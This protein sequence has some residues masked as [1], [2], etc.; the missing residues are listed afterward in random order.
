MATESQ[1]AANQLNALRSTGP[2]SPEGKESSS[3]NA[4]KH[5]LT[6]R[7]A[8]VLPDEK[9]DEFL[10]LRQSLRAQ[11]APLD[12][13]RQILV[14][15]LAA[16]LW[17]LQRVPH[18]EAMLLQAS[19]T[20]HSDSDEPRSVD[21][22][23]QQLQALRDF[24]LPKDV[25]GKISRHEAHLLREIQHLMK[26]LQHHPVP[27]AESPPLAAPSIPHGRPEQDMDSPQQTHERILQSLSQ[28]RY[29]P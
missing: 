15:T 5:G 25:L 29:L 1:I 18:F 24:V 13:L 2:R 7:K 12:P 8:V 22:A 10:A 21:V 28:P 19:P 14:D 26:V 17:R 3:Q 27:V 23:V 6:A 16:N 4:I 20:S 11:Y 9:E